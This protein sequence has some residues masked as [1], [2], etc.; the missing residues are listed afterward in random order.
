MGSK[1]NRLHIIF[2]IFGFLIFSV[3]ILYICQFFTHA[4]E[5]G[6]QTSTVSPPLTGEALTYVTDTARCT[7]TYDSGRNVILCPNSNAANLVFKRMTSTLVGDY[8]NVCITSAD[9]SSNYYTCYTRPAPPVFNDLY[10]IFRP[11]DPV[12]DED[13]MPSDIAPS[14]DT[15]CAS[16]GTTT[17]KINKGITLTLST[18]KSVNATIYSTTVYA[19]ILN[20]LIN[21][22]CGA[23]SENMDTQCSN[24]RTAYTYVTGV[25]DATGLRQAQAVVKDSLDSLSNMSTKTYSMFNGSK[26]NTLSQYALSENI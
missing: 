6:F 19:T 26:C 24:L 20:S 23:T 14:I 15:F 7:V 12:I 9:F 16:Y 2:K 3:G 10:G 18:Y 21:T 13:T 22:Y 4:L 17:I 1:P 25:V 5:E 8:D 11:F